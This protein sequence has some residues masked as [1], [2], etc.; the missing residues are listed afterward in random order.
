MPE[1]LK[2]IQ[3]FYKNASQDP[4]QRSQTVDRRFEA[5]VWSW[6][7]RHPEVSVTPYGEWQHLGLEDAEQKNRELEESANHRDPEADGD[8][9]EAEASPVPSSLRVFVSKER[10]WYALTGHEPDDTKVPASEFLLL[11]IIASRK[12]D[13]I[14]QTDLVRLS[15]QDKRSVPKRTDALAQKGYVEKRPIQI[16]SARTSLVTFRRFVKPATVE[17]IVEGTAEGIPERPI[18]N[19]DA[20]NAKLFEILKEFGIISRNDLKRRLGFEDRW[21]WRVLSRAIR[22]FERIGVLKR[23]RAKSQYNKIHPCVM[24][25]RE[26]TETDIAKF[27]AVSG[28]LNRTADDQADADDDID[29][30][31][32][33]EP[34]GAEED[35]LEMAKDKPVIEAGRAV[36]SWTPDRPVGNQI[37]D[38]VNN[39]GTEGITN[40]V[41]FPDL[42][43]DHI[44]FSN[45]IFFPG[46]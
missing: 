44:M 20:F 41:R 43:L 34:T 40:H 3:D 15:G 27:N 25:V 7:M 42:Q 38:V 36:P 1:I 6:L 29:D 13:G 16:K 32:E 8:E 4:S 28:D 12:S 22:K 26:P 10:M 35:A 18:I 19:F 24:L 45:K 33:N 39:S 30:A 9:A 21:R 5:K 2:A 14:A 11:S 31:A 17:S 23:V 37:F 46:H